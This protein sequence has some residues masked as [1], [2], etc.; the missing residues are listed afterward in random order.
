MQPCTC[1]RRRPTVA[2]VS[3]IC[4]RATQLVSLPRPRPVRILKPLASARTPLAVRLLTVP[5]VAA[6]RA[7]P[8][9]LRERRKTA[10][11]TL[12][13][14]PPHRNKPPA[15]NVV[16]RQQLSPTAEIQPLRC[17]VGSYRVT[18]RT[19]KVTH[20][21]TSRTFLRVRSIVRTMRP[22]AYAALAE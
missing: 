14:G 5:T 10:L 19:Y 22:T 16:A 13:V 17:Q 1:M 3:A 20:Y 21:K 9:K 11:R 6:L 15:F 12:T 2:D 4:T 7:A 8:R 18:P